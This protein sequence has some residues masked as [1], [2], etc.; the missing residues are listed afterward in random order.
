ML[1]KR[2]RFEAEIPTSSMADIAFL[3]LIFFLVTTVIDVD[4]GIGMVLP[5]P[6]DDTVTPPPIPDRDMLKVLVN[7]EGAVLIEDKPAS[8]ATIR[9]RVHEHVTNNGEN[10]E[11]SR[12]PQKAIISLKTDRQTP[13]RIYVDVLDEMRAAYIS[14]RDN[15]ARELGFPNYAA[16]KKDFNDQRD[17]YEENMLSL[18][19]EIDKDA[20]DYPQDE[21]KEAWPLRISIA[22]PDPGQ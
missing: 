18:G 6:L 1:K 2:E 9:E 21:V 16:Y 15:K 19:L 22:E 11:L 20:A 3:L 13:Y 5:P 12:S 7:A 10:P 8:V 4:T 14:L 17:A